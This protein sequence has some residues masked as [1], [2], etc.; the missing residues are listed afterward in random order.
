MSSMLTATVHI[1]SKAVFLTPFRLNSSSWGMC[2]RWK[3]AVRF[4][5]SKWDVIPTISM[6]PGKESRVGSGALCPTR[7]ARWLLEQSAC[8]IGGTAGIGTQAVTRSARQAIKS[9]ASMVLSIVWFDCTQLIM[10]CV[11]RA[12]ASNWVKTS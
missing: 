3:I 6:Y 11:G 10:G 8:C 2:F 7:I 12:I 9:L 4:S 1:Y 5:S